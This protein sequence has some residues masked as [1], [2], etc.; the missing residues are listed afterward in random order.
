MIYTFRSPPYTW[1]MDC[2]FSERFRFESDS[3]VGLARMCV[4]HM[5]ACFRS[6]KLSGML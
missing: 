3:G 5:A 1:R 4:C 2:I 6:G